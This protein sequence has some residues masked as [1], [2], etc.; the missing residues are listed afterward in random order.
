MYEDVID[1]C[2]VEDF[3]DEWDYW[4]K[5]FGNVGNVFVFKN[6]FFKGSCGIMVCFYLKDSYL[7]FGEGEVILKVCVVDG[8]VVCEYEMN[9]QVVNCGVFYLYKFYNFRECL[10]NLWCY[11]INGEGELESCKGKLGL[12]VWGYLMMMMKGKVFIIKS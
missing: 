12:L 6:K 7:L 2:D 8:N 11:C 4:Y 3:K 5:V 1:K 9:I 10:D